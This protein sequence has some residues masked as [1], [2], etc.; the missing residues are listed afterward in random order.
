LS[1]SCE[2]GAMD[3]ITLGR[4]IRSLRRRRGWRQVDLGMR[5]DCA[6]STISLVERGHMDEM[7]IRLLRRISR[8]LEVRIDLVPRWRGGELDRLLN[9]AHAGLQEAFCRYLATVPGWVM[10]PEVSFS[11]FG[12][13]GVIDV[14]AWNEEHEMLLVIE[15][16]TQLVDVMD[17]LATMDRRGRLTPRIAAELGWRSGSVARLVVLADSR[18]NRRHVAE[19]R[20][21]L[22]SAFP[23][24]GRRLDG[25]LRSPAEP[26]SMLT[27]WGDKSASARSGGPTRVRVQ[28]RNARSR[29]A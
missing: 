22:R 14:L 25:W 10:R 8:A 7:S 29:V 26:I 3:D 9:S 18:T 12:E 20:T 21:M 2:V 4:T 13:R 11:I 28:G 15:V 16:K 23:A 17:L 6:A 5:S 19:H 24:D 27:M 1:R